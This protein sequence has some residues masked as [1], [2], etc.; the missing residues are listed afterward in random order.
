MIDVKKKKKTECTIVLIYWY[1]I[2]VS[3][4]FSKRLTF[5]RNKQPAFTAYFGAVRFTGW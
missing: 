4:G 1:N 5:S 3:A 2:T